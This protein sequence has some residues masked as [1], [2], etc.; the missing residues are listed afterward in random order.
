MWIIAIIF[1]AHSLHRMNRKMEEKHIPLMG[2]FSAFI[3]AGQMLNIPIAG[4]TSGHLLG[5]VLVAIFLGPSG[6]TIVMSTVLTVQAIFFQ[7][8]G[9]TTL[10]ANIFNIGIVGTVLGYYVYRG[11]KA[12]GGIFISAAIS[13]WLAVFLG[14][15][16]CA[17]QLSASGVSP[18]VVVLPAMA[19]VHAVIGIIEAGITVGV[20][21]V[22]IQSRPDLMEL[23]KI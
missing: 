18:L 11:L 13:A 15:S 10:G 8:G 22:V 12:I 21:S 6:G 23:Q 20:I 2:V 4:G 16:A 5:S 17:V 7:D 1:V 3:F 19:G 9:I 14:A